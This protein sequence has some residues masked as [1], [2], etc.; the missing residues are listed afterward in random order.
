MKKT[1][2]LLFPL[3]LLAVTH[4][5]NAQ[6]IDPYSFAEGLGARACVT[7]PEGLTGKG[8]LVGIVDD[9]IEFNHINFLDPSTFQTRVEYACIFDQG[10]CIEAR[11]PEAVSQLSS[12]T[13]G[14]EHGTHVA[15]IAAGSYAAEG[16]QGI[17][18]EAKLCL[19]D[20]NSN[21]KRYRESLK[22]IFAVA[23]SLN[24]PLVVNMS[25]GFNKNL[26]GFDEM[27]QLCDELTEQGTRPGRIIT[28]SSG[29]NG[30]ELTGC[31]GTIGAE[32]KAR[33]AISTG[34]ETG[35]DEDIQGLSFLFQTLEDSELDFRFF[36]YDKATKAETETGITDLDGNPYDISELKDYVDNVTKSPSPYRYYSLI[37]ESLNISKNVVPCVEIIGPEGTELRYMEDLYSMEDNDYF[38]PLREVYGKPNA[39]ALTSSVISVGNYDTHT[40][41]TMIER[42]SSFGINKQGEKMPDVVAPGCGI[43]SSVR[44]YD[45]DDQYKRYGQ[46][47][48]TMPDG[49]T[50]T[51]NWRTMR[52]TSQSAPLV[53]GLCALMLQY[54]PTLTVNR[55]RELL[56]STNDWNE[57]CD[58]APMGPDQAGYGILNTRALF[59][60]LMG[61]TSIDAIN[62]APVESPLYDLYGNRLKQAP[63]QGFYIGN[64]GKKVFGVS[65]HRPAR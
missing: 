30:N 63:A 22:N 12:N 10:D 5:A 2:S 9:G 34:Q 60:A 45:P 26:D 41:A 64:G 20:A 56:H 6:R 23:D 48:V 38:T 21:V 27:T 11:T 4:P 46:R 51:F 50:Q 40:S 55:V 53:A 59:E 13:E 3:T 33:F 36:L 1:F 16:W 25:V 57:Y 62:D 52:G 31:E 49:S 18:P 35:N 19:A 14:K 15:G 43:I 37:G 29:N 47:E 32:G 42:V 7:L 58:N 54:D 39:Y 28:V 8:I 17:A 65:S 44:F 61:G 24:L